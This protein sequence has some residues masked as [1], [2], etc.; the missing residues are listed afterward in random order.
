MGIKNGDILHAVGGHPL[1]LAEDFAPILVMMQE[2]AVGSRLE[3]ELTRRNQ[4]MTVQIEL[5]GGEG[6]VKVE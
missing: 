4:T 5:V 3:L 2:D 6:W 1:L